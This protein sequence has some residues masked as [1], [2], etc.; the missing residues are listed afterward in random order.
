MKILVIDDKVENQQSAELLRGCGHEV[1]IFDGP[2]SG[3]L[4]FLATGKKADLIMTDMMMPPGEMMDANRT[5]PERRTIEQPLGL[6][7]ALKACCLGIPVAVCSNLDHH[8][9]E[10]P[11][12][13][14]WVR[15]GMDMPNPPVVFISDDGQKEARNW[16]EIL[17]EAQ[18]KMSL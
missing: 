14:G 6:V 2:G 7:I 18:R 9:T 11:A 3:L 5:T 1:V 13:M 8:R 17:E 15:L 4:N 10:I 16:V 12:L